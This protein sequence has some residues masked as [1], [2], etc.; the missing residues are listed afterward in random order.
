MSENSRSAAPGKSAALRRLSVVAVAVSVGALAAPLG[1]QA[2]STHELDRRGVTHIIVTREQNLSAAQSA[3]ARADAG[4]EFV[5]RLPLPR[6]ELVEAEPGRLAEALAS[7]RADPRVAYAV[8]DV[9]LHGASRDPLWG[10]QWALDNAGQPAPTFG[11]GMS[12]GVADADVD[13]PQAWTR[14]IGAGETIAIVDTGIDFRHPEFQGRIATNRAEAGANATNGR[15]DDGNGYVDDHRGWDWIGATN[16]EMFPSAPRVP[17]NDPSDGNGHGTHVAGIAVAGQDNDEGVTGIA[18]G[19]QVL[20]L[21]ILDAKNGGGS[22]SSAVEAFSY[23]AERG[24]RIVSASLGFD[25]TALQAKPL[26]DVVTRYPGTLFVFAAGNGD[27]YGGYNMDANGT[28]ADARRFYPCA[29]TNPNI[30]CVGASSASDVA[31]GFSNWGAQS[32]DVHAPGVGICSTTRTAGGGYATLH[33]TSMAAPLVAGSLALLASTDARL[34]SSQLKARLL[35]TVDA[36]SALAGRSTTGGRV[37]AAAAIG[38]S[39]ANL[40][41]GAAPSAPTG[42][43]AP[44][45]QVQEPPAEPTPE[46]PAPPVA[47]AAPPAAVPSPSSAQ[48]DNVP[49]APVAG[50]TGAP[51]LSSLTVSGRILRRSLT[52]AFRLDRPAAVKLTLARKVCRDGRCRFVSARTLN[53]S[54]RKGANRVLVRRGL[55]GRRL[56]AGAYRLT[57]QATNAGRRSTARSA[58]L[59]VR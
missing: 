47:P 7:L 56:A 33:G 24:A 25:G 52:V 6:T 4:V 41:T 14:T 43:V 12:P 8:A 10:D 27:G 20:P 59:R 55:G 23:A 58:A 15:D 2:A 5:D 50:S 37:N 45:R 18:P 30:V 17:D 35:S 44:V 51:T 29:L 48:P 57:V 49:T 34:S 38:A 3:D 40:T 54:G 19:A 42:C 28:S 32:V 9:P 16:A 39:T 21:R 11:G 46:T 26:G 31:A 53:V 1:A 13:A 36:K 22:L